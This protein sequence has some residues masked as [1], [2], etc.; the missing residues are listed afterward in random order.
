MV[1][2]TI[3]MGAV[4]GISRCEVPEL[5]VDFGQVVLMECAAAA[6]SRA[7]AVLD[8]IH[9]S[10]P[11]SPYK[12]M[13]TACSILEN[14]LEMIRTSI[15]SKQRAEAFVYVLSDYLYQIYEEETLIHPTS[16]P[17][18]FEYVTLWM[19]IEITNTL[20]QY[21]MVGKKECREKISNMYV[22]EDIILS[23]SEKIVN[24]P[25][26]AKTPESVQ[27]P[28]LD[29]LFAP[30]LLFSTPQ[31]SPPTPQSMFPSFDEETLNK[32]GNEE[33]QNF[34]FTLHE[35]AMK[36]AE[37][38]CKGVEKFNG[39]NTG[40]FIFW[41][42]FTTEL[43]MNY[44]CSNDWTGYYIVFHT[45]AGPAVEVAHSIPLQP[46]AQ[47]SLST[48]LKV[49]DHKYLTPH[50]LSEFETN[51]ENMRQEPSESC[52]S[53]ANRFMRLN[54][55]RTRLFGIMNDL[56][57]R[58]KFS[59]GLR[60]EFGWIR[61]IADGL[62]VSFDSYMQMII[63]YTR[64]PGLTQTSTMIRTQVN[65]VEHQKYKTKE[66][67]CF[68]CD[69]TG[70]F[71]SSCTAPFADKGKCQYG[72][73]NHQAAHCSKERSSLICNRCK[74]SGHLSGVCRASSPS[75]NVVADLSVTNKAISI[76]CSAVN[77]NCDSGGIPLSELVA[78]SIELNFMIG[79]SSR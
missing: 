30:P 22:N 62:N 41:R 69:K 10:R 9:Y 65:A 32:D 31:N 38:F 77:T 50:L 54:S 53:Y 76:S 59:R 7:C 36:R 74:K 45:L 8:G 73:G 55:I 52:E 34:D 6:F 3:P 14:D 70:H 19:G 4:R 58:I 61:S 44:R 78:P 16:L 37:L 15:T 1:N 72:A 26:M 33:G 49:M 5:I 64:S 11:F 42:Y 17:Q 40:S 75:G 18:G 39:I 68:R 2:E 20:S 51:F 48:L 67:V 13:A 24:L 27:A 12:E 21:K 29:H 47:R 56:Q 25:T 23:D 60:S 79:T 63:S 66:S 71:A 46:T 43:I 35:K 57:L 28:S